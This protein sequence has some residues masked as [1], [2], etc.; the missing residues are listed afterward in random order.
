MRI[1]KEVEAPAGA[2]GCLEPQQNTRSYRN[3]QTFLEPGGELCSQ[4]ACPIFY[5]GAM[6]SEPC[7]SKSGYKNPVVRK[8]NSDPLAGN[9]GSCF[10]HGET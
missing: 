7:A 4:L 1:P 10:V 3:L 9:V 8:S 2:G 6:P 5:C